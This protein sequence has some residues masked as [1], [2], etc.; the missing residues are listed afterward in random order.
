MISYV[1]VYMYIAS[2]VY[3][4]I[5]C[6]CNLIKFVAEILCHRSNKP[7][8]TLHFHNS[9]YYT[10]WLFGNL[11]ISGGTMIHSHHILPA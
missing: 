10:A 9:L 4:Y 2:Y 11:Y 6:Q 8:Q 5:Y 1:Y 3:I 7:L